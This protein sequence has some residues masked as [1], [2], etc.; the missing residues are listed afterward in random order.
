MRAVT[1]AALGLVVATVALMPAVCFGQ[2]DEEKAAAAVAEFAKTYREEIVASGELMIW[3]GICEPHIEKKSV[4]FY[5]S[6]YAVTDAPSSD[7]LNQGLANL[8]MQMY[9][10][11]RKERG[12]STLGRAQCVETVREAVADLAAAQAKRA[13]DEKAPK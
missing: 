5:L 10:R 1:A 4:D 2:T 13:A 12:S 8:H 7:F 9:L 3:I 6:E 11:G